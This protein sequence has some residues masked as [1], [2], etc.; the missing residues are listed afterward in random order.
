MESPSAT[1]GASWKNAS[2]ET[3]RSQ[4][5]VLAFYSEKWL[6]DPCFDDFDLR[7]PKVQ[8]PFGAKLSGIRQRR[9]R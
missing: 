9:M 5:P 6:R 7:P 1:E 3:L 8:A 4:D 2:G